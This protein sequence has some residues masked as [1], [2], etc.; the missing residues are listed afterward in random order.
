[1]RKKKRG[2]PESKRGWAVEM[3]EEEY[4]DDNDEWEAE[5]E[6]AMEIQ[7]ELL[8]LEEEEEEVDD[9]R[10]ENN[11]AVAKEIRKGMSFSQ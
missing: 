4:P 11:L 8:G 2:N 7:R 3:E 9:F 10:R 5:N 6:A 1:M